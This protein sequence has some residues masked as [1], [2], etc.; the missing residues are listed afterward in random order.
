MAKGATVTAAALKAYRAE[1][2]RLKKGRQLRSA[3]DAA[4]Y[5]DERGFVYF[6]PIKGVDLPSLWTA[7]AGERPV[8]DQHDDPGHVTWGWK[9][10]MLGARRW[11]YGKLLRGKATMV[12]FDTLPYFYALSEN[13]GDQ[14]D[15][16]MEYEA[17]RLTAEAKQ[18]Y[19]ALLAKGAL[20]SLALRRE[21]R[22][23]G[24]ESNTRFDRAVVDLQRS[25]RIL[26]IGVAKAGAWNYAFIYELLDRW[27][28]EVVT[29]AREIGRGEARV[30]LTDL[31]LQSVG[32][33]PAN[34]VGKLFG[35]PT[36]DVGKAL[37]R[38]AETGRAKEVDGVGGAAGRQWVT[39]ALL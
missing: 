10:A 34:A 39:A 26:P 21:A 13:Y 5:V 32:V 19:E 7:V 22:L 11:Y 14:D 18:V 36:A 28:P 25:L 38:L 15:Y 27:L 2:F 23:L 3:D 30:H 37:G 20:D 29:A 9:D 31:L 6:W 12:S 35:W 4:R 8:A 17:G 16:L 33:A 24:K 1:T